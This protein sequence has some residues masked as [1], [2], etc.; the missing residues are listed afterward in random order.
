M[1]NGRGVVEFLIHSLPSLSHQHKLMHG[2][3]VEYFK[4]QFWTVYCC[5]KIL[6]LMAHDLKIELMVV[7]LKKRTTITRASV[8]S[9]NDFRLSQKITVNVVILWV[10]GKLCFCNLSIQNH[11][12]CLGKFWHFEN[13]NSSGYFEVSR[14]SRNSCKFSSDI[15]LFE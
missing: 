3:W 2:I 13:H 12:H 10:W 14:K 6:Y 11:Q 5:F 15:F 9:K 4:L 7:G 1:K 8:I